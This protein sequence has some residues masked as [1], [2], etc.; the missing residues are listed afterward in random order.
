M[1]PRR[2][3]RHEK[4]KPRASSPKKT[5]TRASQDGA[6]S[7]TLIETVVESQDG[8]QSLSSLRKIA[9]L[10]IVFSVYTAALFMK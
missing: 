7:P 5:V 6:V 1:D 3:P 8:A 4:L 10:G 9:M 2:S